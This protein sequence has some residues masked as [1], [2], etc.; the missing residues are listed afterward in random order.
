MVVTSTEQIMPTQSF[1]TTITQEAIT[2][3]FTVYHTVIVTDSYSTPSPSLTQSSD[4][5]GSTSC[6][7]SDTDN[8]PIYVAVVIVIVG[9]LITITVAVMGALVCRRYWQGQEKPFSGPTNLLFV[10]NKTQPSMAMTKSDLHG[11]EGL[12]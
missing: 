3:S 12:G 5:A 10:D 7:L 8:T 4:T 1:T 9:L 2:E 6:S 11:R